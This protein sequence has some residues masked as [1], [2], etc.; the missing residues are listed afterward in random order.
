MMFE[1]ITLSDGRNETAHSMW[2]L[3]PLVER[4]MGYEAYRFMRESLEEGEAELKE[5]RSCI[6]ELED[7]KARAE[8]L[9]SDVESQCSSLEEVILWEPIE[10]HEVETVLDGICTAVRRYHGQK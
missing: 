7:V 8:C 6:R 4:Y 5:C 1:T 10:K 2:D 9:A 3:L